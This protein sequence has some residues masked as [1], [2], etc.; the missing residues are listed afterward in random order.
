MASIGYLAEALEDERLAARLTA[1]S[2]IKAPPS[3]VTIASRVPNWRPPAARGANHFMR[4]ML[5]PLPVDS[6]VNTAIEQHYFAPLSCGDSVVTRSTITAIVPKRTRLGEGF[7][8][9]EEIE[10]RTQLGMLVA[11]TTNTMFRFLRGTKPNDNAGGAPARV[12]STQTQEV[13][14]GHTELA[15][16]SMPITMTRLVV[17]A[18]AVRDFS[19][20]HHDVDAAR[21]AGH[22]TAFFSYSFQLALVVKA[23]TRWVDDESRIARVKL[24]LQA[25]M[26]LGRTAVC[27]GT[28][29]AGRGRAFSLP[30]L[31]STEDGAC[32]RGVADITE[33]K[34]S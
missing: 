20:L 17:G 4:A 9:T 13:A 14:D 3:F 34:Q 7:F 24:N 2:P 12:P 29:L 8:L 22:A 30:F 21:S 32:T 18:G 6:S 11:K 33:A 10:H 19:P 16:L 26:Y 5:V 15:P 23:L 1:G 25:P 28:A 31:L 27:S